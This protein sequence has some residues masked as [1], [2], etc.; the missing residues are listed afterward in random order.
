MV[1]TVTGFHHYCCRHSRAKIEDSHWQLQP[2]LD[3]LIWLTD[4]AWPRRFALGLTSTVIT[5]DRTEWRMTVQDSPDITPWATFADAAHLERQFRRY[6]EFGRASE[7]WFVS[8]NP[9]EVI[10]AEPVPPE[11]RYP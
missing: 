3:G 4:L 8:V 2:G 6:L 11:R 9:L 10:T 1:T 7:H 5:C